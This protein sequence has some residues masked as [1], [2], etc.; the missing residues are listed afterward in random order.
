[1]ATSV[2]PIP[3]GYHSVTPY[4]HVQGA[5]R[6]LDF[7]KRVFGAVER[8]RL[9]MPGGLIGH[10]EIEIGGSVIM[11]ADEFPSMKIFGP[12][13]LGG[14][15]VTIHLY[16]HDVDAV[17]ARAVAAGATMVQPVANKFYG[18]RSGT[19][20]D[21]FGHHWG[22][23]T[24]VEDVSPGEIGRRAAELFGGGTSPGAT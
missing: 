3:D 24:H 21:P 10:A 14:T 5:A 20:A 17:V 7:Y 6:A 12:L 22:V 13:T 4:L 11:L 19:F 1:M 2:K 8:M 23:A 16:V 9:D 15:P 18:D